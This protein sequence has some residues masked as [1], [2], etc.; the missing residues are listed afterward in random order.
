MVSR[1]GGLLGPRGWILEVRKELKIQ[2]LPR[3]TESTLAF[4]V[5]QL[6]VV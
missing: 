4:L 1:N 6:L 3:V 2:V 5:G